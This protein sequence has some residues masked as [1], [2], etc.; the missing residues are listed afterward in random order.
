MN[1][2]YVYSL[3]IYIYALC[4]IYIYTLY[5]YIYIFFY[6]GNVS[7]NSLKRNLVFLKA[8]ILPEYFMLNC[9]VSDPFSLYSASEKIP[10]DT[11][12]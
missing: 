9:F 11:F 3:F 2:E 1:Q 5:I 7:K 4:D 8:I 10:S 6:I 12:Y